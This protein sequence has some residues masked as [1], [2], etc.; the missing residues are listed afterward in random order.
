MSDFSTPPALR[1]GD[2]L[3]SGVKTPQSNSSR[4]ASAL[5]ASHVGH[6]SKRAEKKVLVL[7]ILQATCLSKLPCHRQWGK[8]NPG[9]PQTDS[10]F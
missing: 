6:L 4:A 8:E 10:D 2:S 7:K 9:K 5:A 1:P 3:V